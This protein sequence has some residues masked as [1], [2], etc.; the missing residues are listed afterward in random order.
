MFG[1]I[2]VLFGIK[3]TRNEPVSRYCDVFQ[4]D[5]SLER[6]TRRSRVYTLQAA[7]LAVG[8]ETMQP[9]D[10]LYGLK[11][12]IY[13]VIVRQVDAQYEVICICNVQGLMEGEMTTM[14]DEESNLEQIEVY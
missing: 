2:F 9:G 13:P 5:K 11:D 8:P 14:L 7:I 6:S 1:G 3:I 4:G 10:L 12:C